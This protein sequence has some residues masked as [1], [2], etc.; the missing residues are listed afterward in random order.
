[1]VADVIADIADPVSIHGIRFE[2]DARLYESAQI[3]FLT[4]RYEDCSEPNETQLDAHFFFAEPG[5]LTTSTPA[6]LGS[7]PTLTSPEAASRS[8]SDSLWPGSRMRPTLAELD[9][10]SGSNGRVPTS[11]RS[12]R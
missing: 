12:A 6:R 5:S 10:G 9:S 11:A 3:G 7:R 1:M 8:T 2:D 4:I